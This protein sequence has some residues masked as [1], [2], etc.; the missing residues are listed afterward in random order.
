MRTQPVLRAVGLTVLT[1]VI[2]ALSTQFSPTH[3][4]DTLTGA[5]SG[6]VRDRQSDRPIPDAT[7]RFI[8]QASQVPTARRTDSQGE[9]FTGP[10]PPSIYK[11]QVTAP[12]FRTVELVQR[13]IATKDTTVQPLPIVL[14]PEAV[15]QTTLPDKTVPGSTGTVITFPVVDFAPIAQEINDSNGRRGGVFTEEQVRTLPLGASTLTR[16]FDEL[17]LLLPGVALPPQTQGGVAGPGV[18]PGVGSAG[19]FS[20]NGLRSRANNFTVDGS[21]NNDEDIGVRRQGFI[22][23]IPQSIESVEEFNITTLLASAQYGRN[24]AAQ[25]NVISKSGRNSLHGELYGLLNTSHLNA[26]DYF[27]TPSGDRTTNLLVGDKPVLIGSDNQLIPFQSRLNTGG[28]D[29]LTLAQT[30]VT[31]G[32]PIPRFGEGLPNSL[33]NAF[34]FFSGEGQILNANKEANFSVPTIEQRGAF[35]SGATGIFRNP[36]PLPVQSGNVL[37]YPTSIEGDGIFSLFPFPNNPRGV[38]GMNTFTQVLPVSAR[39]EIISGKIDTNFD[40]WNRK[41]RFAAR[42]N[43]TDDER[44]IPVT[45]EALFSG[46]R[47]HVQTQ[48]ISTYLNSDLTSPDSIRP[49]FNQ[50]RFSYGRTRLR[51]DEGR[52]VRCRNSSFT[53]GT[54]PGCLLPIS[55]L[56]DNLSVIRNEPFFI[57]RPALINFTL[58]DDFGLPGTG[59]VLYG[60]DAASTTDQIVGPVGQLIIAGFSPVGVDVFNFPQRRVNNTYQLADNVSGKIDSHS[61][62]FGF[63]IRRSELNSDLPRNSRPLITF[64][65]APRLIGTSFD[66]N[67]FPTAFRVARVGVDSLPFLRPEYFAA[68]SAPSGT[69]MSLSNQAETNINLRFY[70]FN[71]FGQDEWKIGPKFSLSFGIRYEYNSVPE[72][73]GRKIERTFND[74]LIDQTLSGLDKFIG[75]RTRIFDSDR[76][77]LAP[78]VSFAYSPEI[79][80]PRH[81]TV[82]RGGY[83]LYYDQILGAVVSQSRNVFPSFFTVNLGGGPLPYTAFGY[84]FFN[85][86]YTNIGDTPIVSP[87][88]GRPNNLNPEIDPE[89]LIGIVNEFFPNAFGATLPARDLRTPM[90]HQYQIGFEQQLSPTLLLSA[91]YIGTQGRNLLRFTTPNLGPNYLLGPF[92][93][94]APQNADEIVNSPFESPLVPRFYGVT[95]S[96]GATVGANGALENNGRPTRNVGAINQ[97]ETTAESRYDALQVQLQGRWIRGTQFQISY[98]FSKATDDVSDVFDLAGAFSLPQNSLR[99]NERGYANF[100]TRHRVGYSF[101]YRLPQMTAS[102]GILRHTIGGLEIAGTGQFQ[103]GQPFTVNSLFDVNLDGN[104]TDRPNT[105]AGIITTISNRKRLSLTVDPLTLLAAPGQDGA[106]GRNTFRSGG[107]VLVNLALIREFRIPVGRS[108]EFHKLT[109]RAEAFNLTNRANFGI[110]VRFLE[111]PGFGDATT[112]V[113]PGRRIQFGLRYTF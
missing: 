63:D 52:D 74:P 37:A 65:G 22:S 90:S 57:N 48:N 42:Y 96:P 109:F 70:Q 76:N 111:A 67:N 12:G 110:P 36:I 49:F 50:L 72:E 93:F 39:G 95:L 2:I 35:N 54:E 92:L 27:D 113:T 85:P 26:R 87:I 1:S 41:Q 99:I 40:S 98:T 107:F 4:Q 10:L 17:A 3:A 51:F 15:V 21:D 89:G 7:I 102:P 28:K 62:T 77:N 13:L 105:S 101:N 18:G 75:G 103:T 33:N 97:F 58:P 46:I 30:G 23:L 53:A 100:D 55:D 34:F 78:R 38:Y 69:F 8:N 73:S 20:V 86:L 43:L 6:S 71:F 68:A 47:S 31:L 94:V 112:T 19:Q 104:L 29:S 24:L 32:G 11:I 82:I 56:G 79:F 9:F 16:T 91:A 14:E 106:V 108:A 81:T 44:N 5:F 61:I 45:G 64:Y 59:P 80:G 83:G 66:G 84:Q 25:V 60:Y 88:P